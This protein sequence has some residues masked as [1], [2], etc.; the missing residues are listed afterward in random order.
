MEAAAPRPP[1]PEQG[2][3]PVG[4]AEPRRGGRCRRQRALPTPTP[5]AGLSTTPSVCT[6]CSTI[7]DSKSLQRQA[8][9]GKWKTSPTQPK[10]DGAAAPRADPTPSPASLQRWMYPA[11]SRKPEIQLPPLKAFFSGLGLSWRMENLEPGQKSSLI[12]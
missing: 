10:G 3:A 7:L 1:P 2:G 8:R 11:L 5:R 12:V 4:R 9:L 6:D